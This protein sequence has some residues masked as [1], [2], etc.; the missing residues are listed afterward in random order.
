LTSVGKRQL[1][2]SFADE[3][4]IRAADARLYRA[5]EAGHNR[6]VACPES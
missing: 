3:A 6:I 5:K 1:T 4:L 2:S